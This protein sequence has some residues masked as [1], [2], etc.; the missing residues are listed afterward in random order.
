MW[1]KPAKL[2]VYNVQLVKLTRESFESTVYKLGCGVQ[3][4][5]IEVL[6]LAKNQYALLILFSAIKK[7]K[8]AENNP[9]FRN[10]GHLWQ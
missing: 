3:L 2:D 4:K 9:V 10:D 7:T 8:K 1:I 6:N 5:F